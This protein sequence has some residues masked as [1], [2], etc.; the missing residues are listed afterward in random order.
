MSSNGPRAMTPEQISFFTASFV[1]FFV[2]IDAVGVAPVF[3]TLTAGGDSAYRRHMAVKSTI[4]ASLIIF[5]FAFAGAWLMGAMHISIAAFKAAGGILL[6]LIALD[7]VFER[8]TERRAVGGERGKDRSYA[9]R[10]DQDEEGDEAGG[11]K[12]DLFGCHGG[13]GPLS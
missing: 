12:R 5:F 13:R 11:E 10:V 9:D 8:R 7:M 2:L 6:F 3:A 1:T 4:V